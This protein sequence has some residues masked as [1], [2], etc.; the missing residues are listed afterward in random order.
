MY[1]TGDLV[2]VRPDGLFDYCGRADD[3]VKIRG[4]RVELGEVEAA[5]ASCP[6]VGSTVV[7][8]ITAPATGTRQLTAYLVPDGSVEAEELFAAVRDRLASSLPDY[9]VPTSFVLLDRIPMTVNGKLDVRAL[10]EPDSSG[11]NHQPP[12]SPV[13][14]VLCEI[15]ARILG[16]ERVGI[17]DD[18]FGLGGDSI[19]SLAV[20]SAARS[21]GIGL[22]PRA[23]MQKR[24]VRLFGTELTVE[25]N[26]VPEQLAAVTSVEVTDL[27]ADELDEF[28]NS[29]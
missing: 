23:I 24:T 27:S 5:V 15:V 19:T 21:A 13:E 17:D 2:Q 3:Q 11:S 18:F 9:M 25:E 4:Y 29:L 14:T 12:R 6:G 20:A 28:E 10:P 26:P 8:A 22:T 1:R 16:V 7:R